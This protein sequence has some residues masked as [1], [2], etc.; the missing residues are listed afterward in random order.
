MQQGGG[1]VAGAD[2]HGAPGLFAGA[3][4]G[5]VAVHP[6]GQ[7]GIQRKRGGEQGA[8]EIHR[9]GDAPLAEDH[10]RAYHKHRH[11]NHRC[12]TKPE[13]F[14]D[15]GVPPQAVVHAHKAVYDLVAADEEKAAG[16]HQTLVV[17]EHTAAGQ[18]P[19][20]Q[21]GCQQ[22]ADVHKNEDQLPVLPE[23]VQ[24]ILAYIFQK[25]HPF[26]F[27]NFLPAHLSAAGQIKPYRCTVC[28]ILHYFGTRI[29]C[30]AAPGCVIIVKIRGQAAGANIFLSIFRCFADRNF[31]R[32]RPRK[33][34][35][36]IC[37]HSKEAI[38]FHG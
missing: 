3:L 13:K 26:L 19:G 4:E 10:Q 21:V 18:G 32:P 20:N 2:D 7:A 34:L 11:R 22:T 33:P 16:D 38:R 23:R 30:S 14:H 37:A 1:R 6:V 36:L 9:N 12:Q 29:N 8:E 24:S 27:C 31:F 35:P 28:Y 5:D 17:L 15:F 25:V